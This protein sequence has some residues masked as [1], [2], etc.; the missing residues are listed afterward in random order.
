M[1][2]ESSALN[3][4]GK[5]TSEDVAKA[6]RGRI[7]SGDLAVGD[8]MPTQAVLVEEFGVRRSV[9]R[10]ALKLLQQ[11]GLLTE[12]TRGAPARVADHSAR[13]EAADGTPRET[14]VALGPRIT[15]AFGAADVRIDALCLTAESLSAALGEQRRLVHTRESIPAT[16][17]VRVLMPNRSIDLAFPRMVNGPEE[18]D[19]V[20]HRWLKMRNAHGT[21]LS[22][23]LRGL[24]AAHGIDVDVQFKA[25]PFTPPVKLYLLNG[26]EALFAYYRVT[27]REE[28]I[29]RQPVT[30]YDALGGESPLFSFGAGAPGGPGQPHRDHAFVVQSQ[31]WFDALWTTIATDLNLG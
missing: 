31:A 14:M 1:N 12:V 26:T 30:M 27:E 2:P 22:D 10:Q 11:E 21:V 7:D 8:A 19:P 6:L 15:A 29:N 25:L 4:T 20:H 23:H 16:V 28:Q 13:T 18:A 17:K 3:G 5:P 9:V 24:G